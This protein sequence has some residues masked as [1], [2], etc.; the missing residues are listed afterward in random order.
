MHFDIWMI[1]VGIIGIL[2]AWA[3]AGISGSTDRHYAS[4][5]THIV[6]IVLWIIGYAVVTVIVMIGASF[7]KPHTPVNEPLAYTYVAENMGLTSGETYPLMLGGRIGGSEGET[8]VSTSVAHGLFSARATTT[9]QASTAPASAVS[10]GYTYEDKTYIL[11]MPTS[12]ITFFITEEVE[13]SV[14][15]WLSDGATF[16]FGEKVYAPYAAS[17]CTWTF[18]NIL[19]MCLWPEYQDE[20]G[21]RSTISQHAMDVGLAPVISA[22]FDRASITLSQEMYNQLLGIIE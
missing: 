15:M 22:G 12:R 8:D 7:N 14:T 10:L 3:A 2:G 17:D 5:G 1:L 11:E 16:D 20:E 21:P 6:A 18:N 19:W 4:L 9:M 13:P